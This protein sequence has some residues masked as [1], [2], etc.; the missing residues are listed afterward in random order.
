[1]W[2][3]KIKGMNAYTA[4]EVVNLLGYVGFVAVEVHE[5]G[6]WMCIICRK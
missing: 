6:D 5:K 3:N 1:M 2:T 4:D